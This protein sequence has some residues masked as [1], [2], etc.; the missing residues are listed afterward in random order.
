MDFP[1][2]FKRMRMAVEEHPGYLA[3]RFTGTYDFDDFYLAVSVMQEACVE[4]GREKALIDLLA[5]EGNMPDFDRHSIGI[6]YA[7]VWGP[8]MKAA[9]VAPAPKVNHFMENTAVNRQ[10]RLKVFFSEAPA[11][12]WLRLP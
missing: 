1:G 9:G 7:E 8:R 10:G 5:V 11:L 6:R 2:T 3:F 4:R 12:E